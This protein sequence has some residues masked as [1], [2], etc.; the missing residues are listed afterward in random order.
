M[1]EHQAELERIRSAYRDRDASGATAGTRWSWGE[2]GYR[3]YMQ[4]LEWAL[5]D[6]LARNGTSFAGSRV[7]EVGCGSGYFLHRLKEY[8]AGH[9]AGIDLMD[10]RI[11]QGR[12]RYP[13][14]ELVAGNAAALPW[15]DGSFEV[16]TQFTC[17]SSVLDANLRARI[18]AEMWRV[19]APGGTM[20]SFDMLPT[21]TLMRVARARHQRRRPPAGGEATATTPIELDEL[22]RIFPNGTLHSRTLMVDASLAALSARSRVVAQIVA[23]LPVLHTHLLGIVGKPR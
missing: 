8:G 17:L 4:Q 13:T 5:L 20:L 1:D 12:A 3:F 22:R 6:A 19:L 11:E 9:A 23:A 2:P 7:L 16:V 10:S 21:P 14:L 15:E 18:G